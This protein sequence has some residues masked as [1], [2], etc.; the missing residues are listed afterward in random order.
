MPLM[1]LMLAACTPGS[2]VSRLLD[3]V[4]LFV[5]LAAICIGLFGIAFLAGMLWLVIKN[6]RAPSP[7]STVFARILGGIIVVAGL[8]AVLGALPDA[9]DTSDVIGA[10]VGAALCIGLGVGLFA[11]GARGAKALKAAAPP[12][13]QPPQQP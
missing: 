12:V 13:A 4:E 9:T 1:A 10:L 3:T 8:V 7:V 2:E 5:Q 11:S 6:L